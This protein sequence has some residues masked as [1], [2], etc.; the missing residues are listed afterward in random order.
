MIPQKRI[1]NRDQ[2]D[3]IIVPSE[4]MAIQ[5]Q[6]ESFIKRVNYIKKMHKKGSLI[7][8]VCTGAFLLAS[9][10]LLDGKVATTHWAMEKLFKREFPKVKL[11]T[12]LILADAGKILTSGGVSADS[13]LA[14]ELI[15]K[16]C[17][18]ELAYQSSRCTL[19]SQKKRTQ[20]QFKT[21]FFEKDHRDKE[22]LQCQRHIKENLS[23]NLSV[24]LI[25]KKFSFSTRNLNRRFQAALGVSVLRYIQHTKVEEAKLMLVRENVSFDEITHR[26]GYENV[27]FFRKLFKNLVGLTPKEY[28]KNF[29]A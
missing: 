24:E 21:Y 15:T 26:L 22:V 4:G 14:M 17:G 11:D 5:L 7:A 28:E 3:I 20:K 16:F 12:N 27:S 23:S 1:S 6:S 2:F 9:A 8:S 10:G 13:D 19:V 29:Y 18:N 25:A